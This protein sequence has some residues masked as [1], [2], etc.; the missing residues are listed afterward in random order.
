MD[1]TISPFSLPQRSGKSGSTVDEFNRVLVAKG[2]NVFSDLIFQCRICEEDAGNAVFIK[3]FLQPVI[4]VDRD[5]VYQI[6]VSSI[7]RGNN[8]AEIEI[9]PVSQSTDFLL[10]ELSCTYDKCLA[11]LADREV[12]FLNEKEI[13][14]AD[15]ADKG[16][17]E[18]DNPR[19]IG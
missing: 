6:T 13:T 12:L 9:V 16:E 17:Q 7:I 18:D 15:Q 19:I 11:R 3:Q 1:E 10:P 5:A 14:K 8:T 4:P 2:Y